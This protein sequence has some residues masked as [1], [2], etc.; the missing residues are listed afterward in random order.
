[1]RG[2]AADRAALGLDDHIREAAPVVDP[3]VGLVHGVVA[4]V[5][6]GDV[7]V[8]AVRVLH[9]ELASPDDAEPRPGLVAELGLDLVHRDRQLLV[10][11]DQI[12]Y[13]A[14]HHLLVG[15]AQAHLVAA[16]QGQL[17]Q[18]VAVGLVPA[19]FL[20]DLDRLQGRHQQLDG[21]GGVHFLP[22]D[23]AGLVQHPQAQRQIRV[24]PR[25]KLADHARPEQE[26]M[27]GS[28]GVGR[29]FLERRNQSIRPAHEIIPPGKPRKARL[30][31]RRTSGQDVGHCDP[32]K[33]RPLEEKRDGLARRENL[34]RTD[35]RR[36][37]DRCGPRP[38]D[39]S[40]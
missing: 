28:H 40:S 21:P 6:L 8:E 7:G 11:V 13:Q 37:Q 31:P 9:H 26:D 19:R 29:G 2:V 14:G 22:N 1:M 12:A 34:D 5:E 30:S 10:R 4:L 36:G 18:Q 17:H 3:A 33:L 38:G 24:R 32:A 27:A 16:A 35:T 23:L 20:P 25:A 39:Q 15:R